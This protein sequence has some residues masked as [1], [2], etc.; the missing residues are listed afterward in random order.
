M[1]NRTRL[2]LLLSIL[3]YGL[4]AVTPAWA[5]ALPHANLLRSDP[6]AGAH[7]AEMPKA[8]VLDFTE[9]IDPFA[10]SVELLNSDSLMILPGP[11]TPHP[12]QPK[13]LTLEL[14]QLPD[15]VYS[16][17]WNVRSI[18]DGHSTRGTVAFSVGPDV[19][20]ASRL[21]AL[22]V[23]DPA[24]ALPWPLDSLARWLNYL[25]VALT[26][27]SLVFGWLVWRPAWR[28]SETSGADDDL[29]VTSLLR[30]FIITGCVALG[31]ATALFVVT[32]AAQI[33]AENLG[34]GL[35]IILTGRSGFLAE[36]RI[37]LLLLLLF[38]ARRLPPA[39]AGTLFPWLSATAVGAALLLTFSLQS[40]GASLGAD[41]PL[42]VSMDFL[43]LTAMS[44]WLGGLPALAVLLWPK[45]L[46]PALTANVVAHVSGVA[47]PSVTVLLLTGIYAMQLHVETGQALTET[48]HGMALSVKL[49]LFAFL[50]GLGAINLLVLSPRLKKSGGTAVE[51]LRR[52][53]HTELF[54]GALILLVV[55][56]VMGVSPALE[57]L[58]AQERLGYTGKAR[59]GDVEMVLRVAPYRVGEN[60]FAVDLTD[61]RPGAAQVPGTVILR[62][63]SEDHRLGVSEVQT[64]T[65]EGRRYTA[66]GAYLSITG[67][68]RVE[69]ILRRAGF[70]DVTHVFELLVE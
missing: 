10:S 2:G 37:V 43:H 3:L 42:A 5:R 51:W 54:A 17:V 65:V 27:G 53:V 70:D 57:A 29:Q 60:E 20:D 49:G 30:R 7:L 23:P 25:S 64:S 47:F 24:T 8:V 38:L 19:P 66:R 16:A 34:R 61:G 58:R 68:W 41:A 22:G 31:V 62:L 33:Q 52:T 67:A 63:T 18:V 45:R 26:I 13:R 48:T 28:E 11:G 6:P 46:P 55:G 36:A 12:D 44:V 15:G 59:S 39:G 35:F 56:V 14:P 9:D 1:W 4:C 32:Q 21:P 69:T 40:H 50:V